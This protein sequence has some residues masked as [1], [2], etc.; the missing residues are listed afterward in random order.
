MY[1]A[2]KIQGVVTHR[3]EPSDGLSS[4]GLDRLAA[5]LEEGIKSGLS[6]RQMETILA[7]S[8]QSSGANCPPNRDTEPLAFSAEA[9]LYLPPSKIYAQGLQNGDLVRMLAPQNETSPLSFLEALSFPIL[10][11]DPAGPY[12][13]CNSQFSEMILGVPVHT[14]Q[15]RKINQLPEPVRAQMKHLLMNMDAAFFQQA[16]TQELESRVLCSDGCFRDF[17]LRGSNVLNASGGIQSIIWVLQDI[18]AHRENELALRKSE[19]QIRE[20]FQNVN[21][22]IFLWEV[23]QGSSQWRC[24][25]VNLA[26]CRMLE[27]SRTELMEM[28]LQDIDLDGFDF[29]SWEIIK[30]SPETRNMIERKWKTKSGGEIPVELNIHA[31]KS[32]EQHM[33][34]STARDITERKDAEARLLH[35]ATH[36][37]LTGLP[38]RNLFQDRLAHALSLTR[39][40]EQMVSVLY[41]DLNGFKSVNDYFGHATGD[42]LLRAVGK[43]LARSIRESDT[44]ARVGGDEFTFIFEGLA[45][46]DDLEGMGEKILQ[47]LAEPIIINRHEFIVAASVGWSIYPIDAQDPET[48]VRKADAA[49]YINKAMNETSL[50]FSRLK[51]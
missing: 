20:L 6:L 38:N 46:L 19:T 27:Y 18:S 8:I 15:N 35:M 39:R 29:H 40:T 32:N 21:E 2:D 10:V 5:L 49:M 1:I 48:L 7:S 36:D 17:T 47:T 42:L 50:R 16:C 41:L 25:N 33:V 3:L 37:A 26:A 12:I 11:L 44:V 51:L 4:E 43:A 30:N 45:N 14:V 13:T 28:N 24:L 23:D 9:P 22:A 34:I 31:F